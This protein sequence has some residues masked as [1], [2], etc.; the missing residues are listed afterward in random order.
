MKIFRL[1]AESTH[2]N[3]DLA[4]DIGFA[5]RFRWVL[6]L[7]LLLLCAAALW[8]FTEPGLSPEAREWINQANKPQTEATEAWQ[9]L[10]DLKSSAN[11]S[12][13]ITASQLE[14][15]MEEA[16]VSSIVAPLYCRL[17]EN[18][19]LSRLLNSSQKLRLEIRDHRALLDQYKQFVDSENFQSPVTA[20]DAATAAYPFLSLGAKLSQFEIILRANS[21]RKSQAT[22]MLNERLPKLR[23]SLALMDTLGL[24]MLTASILSEELDLVAGLYTRALIDPVESLRELSPLEV[25]MAGP[26]RREFLQHVGN[27]EA[28]E[29]DPERIELSN[30]SEGVAA[31]VSRIAYSKNR[32]INS[33]YS[34]YRKLLV[35]A[36]LPTIIIDDAFQRGSGRVED[37]E[38]T[39]LDINSL[40]PAI[41]ATGTRED[42]S[43]YIFRIRDIDGKLKLLRIRFHAPARAPAAFL[44]SI[45]DSVDLSNPYNPQQFVVYDQS[46]KTLCFQG[47]RPDLHS[48]RCI[49]TN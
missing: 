15:M 39:L 9:Q 16:Q 17:R 2:Y 47:P 49:F 44:D 12:T 33:I 31:W 46:K 6:L 36:S 5:V 28:Y 23:K 32:A 40:V 4:I 35:K 42:I 18:G 20:E 11:E 38:K 7:V 27:L 34:K 25:S 3:N 8:I 37:I 10:L 22:Q 29:I 26:L 14:P 19:C 43:D 13:Q 1:T 24:K 48:T 45:P 21:G 30:Q 41:F